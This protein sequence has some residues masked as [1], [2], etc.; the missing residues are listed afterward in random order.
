LCAHGY[1]YNCKTKDPENKDNVRLG[2]EDYGPTKCPGTGNSR[3]LKPSF[4]VLN[5]NNHMPNFFRLAHIKG[6]E[7]LDDCA[8]NSK[9]K[10]REIL[11]KYYVKMIKREIN[12]AKSKKA[13]S[14]KFGEKETRNWVNSL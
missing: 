2:C 6:D 14:K 12:K 8:T 4:N 11:N 1:Y 7:I 10:P 5:T 13:P 3:G 9:D